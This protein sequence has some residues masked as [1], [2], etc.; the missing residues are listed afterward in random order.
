MASDSLISVIGGLLRREN[1]LAREEKAKLKAAEA[2]EAEAEEDE[3]EDEDE[4]PVG[5]PSQKAEQEP[6][7][8]EE[9]EPEADEPPPEA[10]PAP[11][12]PEAEPEDEEEP[13]PE[14]DTKPTGPDP[15]LVAQVAAIIKKELDDD[16]KQEKESEIKLS[17]KKEKVNTKPKLEQEF[18]KGKMNFQEAVR[19]AVTGTHLIEGYEQTVLDILEDEKIDGPLG[20]EPFFEKG[21]LYVEKGSE[22]KAAKA[23]KQSREVNKVPKIVGE[24]LSEEEYLQ[25]EAVSVDGRLKGFREALKRLTYEK[26]KAMKKEGV[27]VPEGLS[28][29][30]AAEFMAAASA[31]KREGKKKF[32]FGG[33]E[34]PVTIKVDIPAKKE[35]AEINYEDMFLEEYDNLNEDGQLEVDVIFELFEDGELTEDEVIEGLADLLTKSGRTKRKIKKLEKEKER[36]AEQ[37][38]DDETLAQ[39]KKDKADRKAAKGPGKIKKGLKAIGK[40]LKKVFGKSD[41]S[42]SDA[43]KAVDA[44]KKAPPGWKKDETGKVVKSESVEEHK[45]TEPHK[46]PH[47]EDEVEAIMALDDAGI[48][49]D[50]NR[51]GQVIVKKK[52][53]KKAHKALEK[54]FPKG[55]WPTVKFED[56]VNEDLDLNTYLEMKM[57]AAAKKKRALWAKTAAGKKSLLKS[58]KRA[59]KVKSGAIKIDKAKGRAMAKARKKGGIRNA[60]EIVSEARNRAK[61]NKPEWETEN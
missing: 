12:E 29:E 35:E 21:K 25:M 28:S 45:G 5:D 58:K 39:L 26:I 46:H 30:G 24:E 50:I 14:G 34:Y 23:L 56:T 10:E 31:A 11:G 47:E 51:K 59:K 6:E 44:G 27:E 52:D 33:K 2:E 49:A 48:K 38:K 18:R 1:R 43:Q 37:A 9:P 15:T 42:Q 53:K 16:K 55:G 61:K 41:V 3:E 54:G 20:Y 19:M 40:G 17:G 32:K 7:D 57:S 13:N 4:D 60:Y 22:K 8:E 36:D